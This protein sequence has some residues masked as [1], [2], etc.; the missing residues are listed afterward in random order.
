MKPAVVVT[1]ALLLH[2]TPDILFAGPSDSKQA[3][4]PAVAG[5]PNVPQDYRIGAEDMLRVAVWREPEFTATVPV[6][7]DGKISVPLLNDVQAAGLTPME[8]ASALTTKLRKY[9]DDPRVTVVVVQMNHE[10]VYII[11]QVLRHGPMTLLP[12]MTVMQALATAG[13]NQFA[14]TKKIYVL[15]SDNGVE[16]KLTVN[17]KRMVKGQNTSE[18]I[19]L[20]TGDTIVV[21]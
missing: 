7:P 13:L 4:P 6:R 17:Y 5:N 19:V 1:V 11:G 21:P 3:A 12:N 15:R 8:L 18:N 14:N 16:K 10:R 9:I 20:K 2:V